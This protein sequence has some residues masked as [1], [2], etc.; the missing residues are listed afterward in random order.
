MK[1]IKYRK[2]SSH[3]ICAISYKQGGQ[4]NHY[5]QTT[6]IQSIYPEHQIKQQ[7]TMR[8]LDELNQFK[9]YVQTKFK[10]CPLYGASHTAATVC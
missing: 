1:C 2:P 4:T 9:Y 8:A 3:F 10:Y 6:A 7:S 5:L